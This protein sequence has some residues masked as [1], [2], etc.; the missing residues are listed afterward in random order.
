MHDMNDLC[1]R[2]LSMFFFYNITYA[3][4]IYKLICSKIHKKHIQL[5]IYIYMWFLFP[6][7]FYFSR[8]R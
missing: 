1:A 5:Y 6:I 3:P 7:P 2:S 4:H 8:A